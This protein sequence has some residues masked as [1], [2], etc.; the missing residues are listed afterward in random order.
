MIN[1]QINVKIQMTNVK[2]NPNV[3]FL[4]FGFDL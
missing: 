3:K 1:D 4:D 2:S